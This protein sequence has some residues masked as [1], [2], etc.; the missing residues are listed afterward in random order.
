MSKRSQ[1]SAWPK[2][3]W[4]PLL[5]LSVVASTRTAAGSLIPC[6]LNQAADTPVTSTTVITC[7]ALTFSNFQVANA[8]GGAPGVVDILAGSDFDTVTGAAYLNFD[9]DLGGSGSEQLLFQVTGGIGQIDMSVGG[10]AA[11]IT[12]TACA[13]PIS[14]GPPLACTDPAGPLG[15]ITGVS[16]QAPFSAVFTT[17]SPVYIG[18]AIGT[19]AGGALTQFTLS[20][21]AP[22]LT[23]APTSMSFSYQ[24]GGAQPAPQ[25]LTI[26]AIAPAPVAFGAAASSVGNWLSVL[27][28]NSTTQTTLAVS[29]NAAGLA[30]GSY[31]GAITI[32]C[33]P[34]TSCTDFN[35]QLTVPVTLTVVQPLSIT[36]TS[37]LP[38]A[39]A[40]AAYS[41]TLT[42]TGG[43]SPYTWTI[44]QGALPPNLVLNSATGQ[45][46]GAPAASGP[47]S[48]AIEVTDSAQNNASAIFTLTVNPPPVITT[49][50][51]LPAGTLGVNYSQALAIDGGTPPFLWTVVQGALPPPLLLNPATG[52]IAGTPTASGAYSFTVQVSDFWGA[53]ASQPF[54]LTI[55]PPSLAAT[56]PSLGFSY[57]QGGSQPP[58]QVL[59]IASSGAAV[60][61]TAA[62]TSSGG[63]WLSVSPLS[64]NTPASLSISVNATGLAPNTYNGSIVITG[65]GAVSPVSVPVTLVVASSSAPYGNFTTIDAPGAGTGPGQGTYAFSINDADTITGHYLDAS[66]VEHGFVGAS[67]GPVTT[68]DAPGAS[69]ASGQGTG[70]LSINEPGAIAGYYDDPSNVRHGF[71]RSASGTITT[72]DAPGAQGTTVYSINDA[73][74]TAG[75]SLDASNVFHGFVRSASGTITTFDAPG[76]GTGLDQGTV[77]GGINDAG[78]IGGYY[79]DGN[80]ASHGFVRAANGTITT[81]D[82]PGAGA[83]AYQGTTGYNINSAGA[84]VGPYL[85]A[86][87]V[88]HGFIRAASGAVTTFDAP[89]AGTGKFQGTYATGIN[90]TGAIAGQYADANNVNHGFVRAASGTIT[91]FDVPG[92]GTGAHQGTL[93]YSI[94]DAGAVAGYYVDGGG[95][96]HAFVTLPN[97]VPAPTSLTFNAPEGGAQP[98]PQTLSISSPDGSPVPFTAAAS[99]TS[100]GNWL[101]VSPVSGTT[102]ASVTVSVATSGLAPGIYA[103]AIT[104]AGTGAA[105][106]LLVVGVTLTVQVGPPTITITT[107]SLLPVGAVGAGYSQSLAAIG[108]TPPYV[109]TVITGALPAGLALNSA[110]GQISGT[111]TTIGA[112]DFTIQARDSQGLIGVKFFSLSID[113]GLVITTGT[114]LPGGTV[115][116][117]YSLMLIAAGGAPPYT[118]ALSGGALPAGVA[119]NGATGVIAG[120]PTASGSASFTIRV[121]DSNRAAATAA[122]TLTVNPALT[123]TSATLPSCTVAAKCS[124]TIP[125]SGGTAPFTYVLSAGALPAGL[126]LNAATGQISGTPSAAGVS[127]FT[128]QVTDSNGAT[129]SQQYKLAVNPPPTITTTSPLP[130]GTVNMSYTV[131]LQASGGTPPYLWGW[132]VGAPAGLALNSGTG[133]ISGTPTVAGTGTF[134]VDVTDANGATAFSPALTLTI[135]GNPAI[136]SVT[137]PPPA[138]GAAYSVQLTAAGTSSPFKWSIS[139]GALPAGLTLSASGLISGTPLAPGTFT[140]TVMVTDASNN[141]ASFAYSLTVAQAPLTLTVQAPSGTALPQQQIPITLTLPEAYPVDLAGEL[142]L[143]FTPNPAAPVV[144]PAIQFSTGG[145]SATFLIPAGQTTAVFPQSPLALQTGT[146]AG[147]IVLTATATAGGVPLTLSNSPGFTVSLPQEPP[148]I[149]VSIQAVTSGFNVVI[150]GYS[151]TRDITQ[152]T[153]TFTPAAGSQLQSATFT[154]S[155]VG[156][157][158]QSY[159]ASD[160]ST[161]YGSQFVY[162]QPFTITSGSAGAL[163][164]VTVTLTNSQGASSAVTATGS[165]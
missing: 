34:A 94:N 47:S 57:Q 71:V 97:L 105:S 14:T 38:P 160:A 63:N 70:P 101:S 28:L 90:G 61:F 137:L 84:I 85:D 123:I 130:A 108:G 32:T 111:P 21:V 78:G 46:T 93:A 30:V 145:D 120:T 4:L 162:T 157:A 133:Q 144:D 64:G 139:A 69:T 75:P 114:Q 54:V 31:N 116:A 74:A 6:T 12:E 148:S 113:A 156:A 125:V 45:I 136:T 153:F 35:G 109:W 65:A 16:N 2:S 87:N 41:E 165:F 89:G 82:A 121:T 103:G 15:Q 3:I 147:N 146:V 96:A 112:S 131:T 141:T 140:F 100:G 164:S 134:S 40:G 138:L 55:N 72:F 107:G 29:V 142:V 110:T 51:P 39:T 117:N 88:Y 33:S 102:G 23:A 161:A 42:A 159:Y 58:A 158:F 48:F 22:N 154:P 98:N 11:T 77:S 124:P 5:L 122:F 83:G 126:T 1:E 115:S 10:S 67:S 43:V 20:F 62:A 18:N 132:T 151:N 155:G 119:L 76:A 99:T 60:S 53:S 135:A 80:N 149:T 86:S 81:F 7:G 26:S 19:V 8:A 49:T 92:A 37:P 128:I 79:V 68:F 91:T 36:I 24:Q 143:Q 66:G 25:G 9:P 56:P 27:P 118:W 95:T 50:S 152:A 44:A 73:G 106:P 150:T 127:S 52:Q 17:T 129:T 104:I 59:N 163:Q 13:S